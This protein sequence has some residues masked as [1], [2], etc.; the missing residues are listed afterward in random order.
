MKTMKA[1]RYSYRAYFAFL[2]L[3]S[4]FVL[5]DLA[6]AAPTVIYR[7]NA[8]GGAL[9]GTP[10]WTVDTK[11]A[12]SP[13]VNAAA[14]GNKTSSTSNSID[15]TDPSLSGIAPPMALFQTER[16]DPSGSSEMQ[17]AF[18]VTAGGNYEVRLYFAETYSG[19][20][21]V[22]ARKF[23]VTIEGALMLNDYDVFSDVG[24]NKGVMKSFTVSS[25]ASLNIDFGHVTENPA[26]K[27]I[28]IL[29]LDG[30]SGGDT[31]PPVIGAVQ[32]TSITT[33]SAT[34]TWTTD[35]ASNSVVDYGTTTGYGSNASDAAQVTSHTVN[36]TGLSPNTLYHYRASSTDGSGNTAS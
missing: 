11:A 33:D 30:G 3:L 19:T 13:Y 1:L 23:D 5:I 6:H 10:N 28:E 18:P 32:A 26:L 24:A 31:T 29:Q 7:V 21:S 15:L 12:P 14:T 4:V 35:E 20:Q 9:T 16:Y 2:T 34:I 22:G 25:D 8:G 36:L 27:G 17:W